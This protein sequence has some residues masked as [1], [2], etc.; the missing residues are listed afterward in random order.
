[1]TGKDTKASQVATGMSG[2]GY[3]WKLSEAFTKSRWL[4]APPKAVQFARRGG[5]TTLAA[6]FGSLVKQA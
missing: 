5:A 4:G 2:C 1:M 3:E 6:F